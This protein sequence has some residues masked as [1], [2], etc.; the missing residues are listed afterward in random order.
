MGDTPSKVAVIGSGLMGAGIATLFV[1][2]GHDVVV[3]DTDAARAEAVAADIGARHEAI[4]EDAVR[5]ADV[6][7]EAVAEDEGIKR[8]LYAR[9]GAVSPGAI[10]AS[11]TS[12]IAPSVLADAVADPRRFAIAHFFNPPGTVPLV[13]V[14]PGPDTDPAVLEILAGML[15]DAGRTPV[16]LRRAVPGF[17]ANRLQAA[18]LREAFALEA[19]GVASFADI[20]HIVRAGLGARWAAAGPFTV[21]DLGGLDVWESVCTR[22]FPDLDASTQ[23]PAALRERVAAGRL[24]AKT[25]EGIYR[26][27]A[28][29]DEN[30]RDRIRRHFALD[31]G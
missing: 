10:V 3:H 13:E 23:A 21:T 4:L 24:G 27:D 22:L 30:V 14:V 17:V 18:L 1:D 12:S 15:T 6:V 8:T 2:A 16:V 5:G 25:G 7:F 11:N 9:I 29:E 26:H 19:E 31:V 20:D 28:A